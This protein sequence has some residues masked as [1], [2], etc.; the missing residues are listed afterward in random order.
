M[1]KLFDE[2]FA[3]VAVTV[4][5]WVEMIVFVAVWAGIV[6]GGWL[7]LQWLVQ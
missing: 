1:G 6:G 4:M 5:H 7:L 3:I 2:L